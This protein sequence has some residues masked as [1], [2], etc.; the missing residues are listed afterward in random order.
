MSEYV[1][2][3][4]LE[5]NGQEISD[6]DSVEEKE[7]DLSK[8]VN[9]MNKSGFFDTIPRYGVSVD[10]V[11]PRDAPEFDFRSV[12]NGTLTIDRQNGTRIT[13][14]GVRTM[15][16]GNTKYDGENAA[17]KTIEFACIDRQEA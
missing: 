3:V 8:R 16:I 11:V 1:S 2:R 12:K 5:V 9:L 7:V 13:F 10:Y 4:N 17:K 6:F 14:T 15:K